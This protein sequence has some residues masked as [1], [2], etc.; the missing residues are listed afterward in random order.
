MSETN[1]PETVKVL[2]T[3]PK[4]LGYEYTG[5]LREAAN[6]DWY[7]DANRPEQWKRNNASCSSYLILRPVPCVDAHRRLSRAEQL[8][9]E[10]MQCCCMDAESHGVG[11]AECIEIAE[12]LREGKS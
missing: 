7:L 12:F 6:G 5:E 9:R 4:H 11:C 3:L 2:M 8:L 1:E 10:K